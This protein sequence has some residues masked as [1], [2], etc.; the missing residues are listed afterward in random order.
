LY[1]ALTCRTVLSPPTDANRLVA[2]PSW[3][4]CTF[5]LYAT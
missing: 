1:S 3:R 5:A 2:V 4:Y